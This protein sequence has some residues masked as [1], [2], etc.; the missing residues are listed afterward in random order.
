MEQMIETAF[1]IQKLSCCDDS[2][3]PLPINIH[4]NTFTTLVHDN[5][6]RV[7]E[8]LSGGGTSHRVNSIAIQPK[9]IG[10]LPLREQQLIQRSK[11]RSIDVPHTE[12]PVYNA[13]NRIGP[14]TM[15]AGDY[16]ENQNYIESKDMN[17]LWALSR[18]NQSNVPSW[19]GFNICR[20]QG[21]DVSSDAIGYLPT[22]NAPA[23]DL[24]TVFEILQRS[25]TIQRQLELP[26]IV[27]VVDQ[28]I[29]A[30]AI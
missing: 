3:I 2:Q 10:P 17:R 21:I 19:T 6:D 1:C 4:P 9:F 27:C 15:P 7:E 22:I 26:Y 13:G 29:Y 28:A 16:H 20:R 14:P 8:T 23:T 25:L 30:K 12:L 18:Q 5:I 11:R 24:A